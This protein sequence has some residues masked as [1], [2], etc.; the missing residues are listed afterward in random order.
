MSKNQ[1]KQKIN[2]ID[3][4]TEEEWSSFKQE[5]QH[6]VKILKKSLN[7]FIEDNKK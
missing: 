2:K 6:D 7:T 1:L 3:E 4:K 5:L